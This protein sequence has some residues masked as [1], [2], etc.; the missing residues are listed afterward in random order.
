M[1]GWHHQLDGHDFEQGPGV[2][3]GQVPG[4]AG[5]ENKS[6]SQQHGSLRKKLIVKNEVERTEMLLRQVSDFNE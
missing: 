4:P 2:G 3:D 1:V 5:K 6:Q